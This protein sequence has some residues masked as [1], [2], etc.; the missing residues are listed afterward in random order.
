VQSKMNEAQLSII[1]VPTNDRERLGTEIRS[2]V[3]EARKI[4]FGLRL[5]ARISGRCPHL[6]KNLVLSKMIAAYLRT[7][8]VQK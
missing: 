7:I 3:V 1:E 8:E 2:E 5:H 4:I 6:R